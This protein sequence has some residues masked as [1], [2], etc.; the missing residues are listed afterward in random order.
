MKVGDLIRHKTTGWTAV[1]LELLD[2]SSDAGMMTVITHAG[3]GQWRMS[4]C[5]V[6]K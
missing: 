6:V 4:S 3:P 5:E 1:I 2:S